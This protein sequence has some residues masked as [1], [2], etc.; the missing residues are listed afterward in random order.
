MHY[1]NTVFWFFQF[2]II[3]NIQSTTCH[4]QQ[5]RW[6]PYPMLQAGIVQSRPQVP[7]HNLEIR[8]FPNIIYLHQPAQRNCQHEAHK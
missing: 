4:F 6:F 1:R 5:T 8:L 7:T 3:T 2:F